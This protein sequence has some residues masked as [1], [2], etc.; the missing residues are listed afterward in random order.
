MRCCDILLDHAPRRFGK[1][2][3]LKFE[4]RPKY[5]YAYV[6]GEKDSYEISKQY[7]TEI[8]ERL[9]ESGFDRVLIDEDIEEVVSLMDEF[10]LVSELPEIGFTGIR[11]AFYDRK[12]EHK[13]LNEFGELVASNRGMN[14]RVFNDL[15]LAVAWIS[16]H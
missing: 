13:D 6:S 7:W 4:H 10:Q 3:F 1:A 8:A 15:E 9:K 16:S 5:L 11:I 14:A 12:I 2:L